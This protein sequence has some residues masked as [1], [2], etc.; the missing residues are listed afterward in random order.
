MPISLERIQRR[1]EKQVGARDATRKFLDDLEPT[2]REIKA[3]LWP[4]SEHYITAERFAEMQVEAIRLRQVA[5]DARRWIDGH[6]SLIVKRAKTRKSGK[7]S[8]DYHFLIKRLNIADL[9]LRSF[10]AVA[11]VRP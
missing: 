3:L 8:A 2:L 6:S 4:E 10:L 9:T 1:R 5:K 7:L 11:A